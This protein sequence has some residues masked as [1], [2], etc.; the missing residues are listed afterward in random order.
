VTS[1][2]LIYRLADEVPAMRVADYLAAAGHEV[3]TAEPDTGQ[4][5]QAEFASVMDRCDGFVVL[6][7]SRNHPSVPS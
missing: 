1:V 5:W 6:R 4:D 2:S 7:R 3:A